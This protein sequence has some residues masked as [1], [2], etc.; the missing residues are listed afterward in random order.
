MVNVVHSPT[1][2]ETEQAASPRAEAK[3]EHSRGLLL[4]GLFKLSKAVFFTVVGVGALRLVHQDLGE[5]VMGVVDKLHFDPESRL[6]GFLLDKAD[7][8]G[9]HQ[10][11]EA[12]MF[13]FAYAVLCL[14]EGWGLITE[15][16][17]AEYF[18]VCLTMAALPWESYELMEKLEPYKVVMLVVN[19][20]V[21]AY[22]LW[23][24]KR[25]K[26]G[27]IPQG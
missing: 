27:S 24:L 4:V 25:K 5:V 1:E 12:G 26:Q 20:V 18:T 17:W 10:L 22:L 16:V 23:V 9:H 2:P 15:K 6:V 3:G 13:A 21:L 14:V 19:L 8:I 7:V 11:R